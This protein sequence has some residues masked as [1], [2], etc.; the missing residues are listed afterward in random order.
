MYGP[1]SDSEGSDPVAVEASV[2]PSPSQIQAGYNSFGRPSM[3]AQQSS[4]NAVNQHSRGDE[5]SSDD[6][7]D[8]EDDT[9][10]ARPAPRGK[11]L[12]LSGMALPEAD[13]SD[14]DDDDDDTNEPLKAEVTTIAPNPPPRGK[15]LRLPPKGDDDSSS[16]DEPLANLKPNRNGSRKRKDAPNAGDS[17]SDDDDD[18]V[19]ATVVEG[20]DA[21][22]VMAVA[23]VITSNKKVK[24]NDGKAKKASTAKKSP[25]SKKKTSPA[26]K[27]GA[28]SSKTKVPDGLP[29]VPADKAE[30]SQKARSKLRKNVTSLPFAVSEN[31][32]IRSFGKIKHEFRNQL[33]ETFYSSPSAIYPVGFSCDRFMFSPVHNRVIT[34]RCDILEGG[35]KRDTKVEPSLVDEDDSSRGKKSSVGGPVFRII[36]GEGIEQDDPMDSCNFD[37]NIAS[38]YTDAS[39]K[40]KPEV[41]MRVNVKIGSN[42][43]GGIITKAKAPAKSG[44]NK[45][46]SMITIKYDDGVTEETPFPDPDI[47]LAPPGCPPIATGTD[48]LTEI[49]GKPVLTVS[50]NSPL[51][52]WGKTLLSLGLIDEIMLED[53]LKAL[54]VSRDEG[55]NEAKEKVD[56]FNRKRREDRA[57]TNEDRR[58]SNRE[59]PSKYRKEDDNDIATDGVDRNKDKGATD[60]NGSQVEAKKLDDNGEMKKPKETETNGEMKENDAELSPKADVEVLPKTDGIPQPKVDDNKEP[61]SS[62]ESELRDKMKQLQ[63]MLSE[64]KKRSKIASVDLAN[65]RIATISPFAGNP[66]ICSEDSAASE[67]SWMANA[68]KKERTKMG[69]SGKKKKIVK[70]TS[71]MERNDTFFI[72]KTERLVEGL[73]GA[74]YTPAYVFHAN[75]SASADNSWVHEAKL[76]YQKQRQKKEEKKK[77][78]KKMSVTKAKTD[79]EREVKKRLR[80]EETASRK[81]QKDEEE[82]KKKQNRVEKRLAQLNIQMDDKLFKEALLARERNLQN[83]VRGMNKEYNRRRKAAELVV[84]NKLEHSKFSTSDSASSLVTFRTMLP[85]LSRPYDEEVVR[86]WDFVHSFSGAL[87]ESTT[88][89]SMPSLDTLQDAVNS[90]KI[91]SAD[92]KKNRTEAVQLM[93]GI[94]I[95]LCRVISPS[96]TKTLSSSI[97]NVDTVGVDGVSDG[98]QKE[99]DVSCLPVTEWTWREVARM[100]IIW[101]VLTDIGCSKSEASNIVKGYRSGGHPNSKEA[102]R[103]KKIE[104]SII[105]MMYQQLNNHDSSQYRR[106]LVT[107]CMSTPSVPSAAPSDWYFYLHNIKSRSSSSLSFVKENVEKSLTALRNSDS[108]GKDGFISDLEKCLAALR[109]AGTCVSELHKAKEMAINILDRADEKQKVSALKVVTADQ[110]SLTQEPERQKM[111]LLKL[112]QVSRDEYKMTDTAKEEYMAAALRLKEKLEMKD[113]IADDDDDDKSDDE[114]DGNT[115]SEEKASKDSAASNAQENGASTSDLKSDGKTESMSANGH[116]TVSAKEAEIP[117]E[118]AEGFP[119]GWVTRRL[120]R[121]NANDPRMDRYFYSPK[122]GLKFRSKDDA[123]RF[124]NKVEDA[125]GDEAEAIIAFHGRKRGRPPA[126]TPAAVAAAEYDFCADIASAPDLIRRCLVV[127]RTLCASASA[128]PFIYPVDPQIYP[129]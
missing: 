21:N 87:K 53:A 94:A 42:T 71:M 58:R 129:A 33:D 90:L 110:T 126:A 12:R 13:S 108:E 70:P 31:Q 122:L 62:A 63:A 28:K 74:E 105:F 29:S 113:A 78:V 116:P 96:L 120:P 107:T 51:E 59:S 35:T 41:G 72:P 48:K 65:T 60:E 119:D 64:A 106:R 44:K 69:A 91:K 117:S 50:A 67:M 19:A 123:K 66:F 1:D 102:K 124:L 104:D 38:D 112:F 103:W 15:V 17:D 43:V 26:A 40:K 68:V 16:D 121:N 76:K 22:D 128:S 57:K 8:D 4:F 88:L 25:A 101:D 20:G 56:A 89:P 93:K 84:G 75:R 97:P 114:E 85:P 125:N 36:W 82:D 24:T 79:K 32:I 99:A 54:Q 14:D 7:D 61:P 6:S 86:V 73:P 92:G 98:P 37:A 39:K 23:K 47:H 34:L 81:R 45:G 83:F 10:A 2:N 109:Q 30:A 49:K 27:K 46:L 80:D 115:N 127:V 111:G 18:A 5:N 52:A 118:A 77:K 55:F 11:E 9:V 100:I 95:T 3:F